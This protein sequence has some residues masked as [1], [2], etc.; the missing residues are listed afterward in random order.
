MVGGC[1]DDQDLGNRVEADFD[2]AYV[3][4]SSLRK[5]TAGH[6]NS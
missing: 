1:I 5:S 6:F 3:I 4:F 2:I